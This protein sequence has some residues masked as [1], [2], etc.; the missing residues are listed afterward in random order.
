MVGLVC[1]KLIGSAEAGT[2]ASFIDISVMCT[3]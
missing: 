3:V 2:S 1:Y